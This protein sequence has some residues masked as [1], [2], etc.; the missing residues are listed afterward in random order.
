MPC[1]LIQ[2]LNIFWEISDDPQILMLTVYLISLPLP[3]NDMYLLW[4]QTVY[5][6]FGLVPNAFNLKKPPLWNVLLYSGSILPETLS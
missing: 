6:D 1:I 2:Y 5:C 4:N 3:E